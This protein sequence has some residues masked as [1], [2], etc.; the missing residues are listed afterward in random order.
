MALGWLGGG[1]V[2]HPMA[3]ARQAR[4]IVEA[5]PAADPSRAL[6]DIAE[7]LESVTRTDGFRLE[8]RFENVDLLDAA[9]KVPL[10]KLA[11]D[12][13]STPRLQKFQEQRLWSGIHGFWKELGEAYLRCVHEHEAGKSGASALR[14]HLPAV[15]ARG[16]RALA[17]QLKWTLLRYGPVEPRIWSDLSRLYQLAEKKGFAQEVVAV[18]PGAHGASSAQRELLRALMLC[19][20]STDGLYPQGQ[21]IAERAVAHFAEAFR[22]SPQPEGC[23]HC[24]DLAAPR[25][26]A[27]LYQ[28]VE[29][30]PAKRFFGA[31]EA[32]ARLEQL[33]AQVQ[34]TGAPP[35]DIHLGGSY[36]GEVVAGVLKHLVRYWSDSPPARSAERRSTTG[37]ITVIPGLEGVLGTLDPCAS[38]D[39]DF[40][41]VPSAESWIVENVSAG[42]CG[43][44]VPA[45]RNDWIR[46]G[47][48]VGVH[49]ETSPYWGLGLVRRIARDEQ[50]QRRVGMQLIARTAIAIRVA[51]SGAP[52]SEPA[53]LLSTAPDARGEI[54]LVLRA[55]YYNGR[56][57]LE[58]ALR[59]KSYLLLPAC[60]VE[61]GED[62]DWFKFRIMQRS[63]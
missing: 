11:Q 58:M 48:L 5:L 47:M 10:R 63:P 21:E 23:T 41:H 9:A 16:M 22:L 53:I 42:G 12:Y 18:Y 50:Q 37:R 26:P 17:M 59:E 30:A 20:S 49:S 31:G 39:L 8:R 3:D 19:A 36:S 14:K 24:F 44:I 7:W 54:G 34:R 55:G 4:E 2:D 62:F 13:L 60:L 32:L 38:D 35:S 15:V 56:D 33:C 52:E 27:R 61:A 6:A 46:V 1:K 43:A 57:S 40:S 28:R 29:P 45:Q 25:M 51:R